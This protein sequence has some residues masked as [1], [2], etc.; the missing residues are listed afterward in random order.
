MASYLPLSFSLN[1]E[2]L[3]VINFHRVFTRNTWSTTIFNAYVVYTMNMHKKQTRKSD[4]PYANFSMVKVF[5]YS[6]TTTIKPP[7]QEMIIQRL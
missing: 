1:T 3:S 6:Y 2:E 4:Y 7:A 5:S